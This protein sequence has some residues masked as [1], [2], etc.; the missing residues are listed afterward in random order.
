M[1]M[2]MLAILLGCQPSPLGP[3]GAAQAGGETVPVADTTWEGVLEVDFEGFE[4]TQQLRDD[5]SVF[6][7]ENLH[8][9]HVFL[10]RDVAFT[11][12]GLTR[13]M[14]FDWVDQGPNSVSVGRGIL[15]P[16]SV[17][18]IWTEVAVRFSANYT[19]CNPAKPPCAHKLLF[20]LVRPD[21][22]ERWDVNLGGAGEPGPDVHVTMSG[23]FGHLEARPDEDR[24]MWGVA[25]ARGWSL[26][27]YDL[28]PANRYFD[29]QWHVLRLHA[30]H[31]SGEWTFDARMRLWI[32]GELLYDSEQIRYEYG[33]GGF[34]TLDGARV[35]A[36]LLGRNKDK[37]LDKGTESVW[38]G[39]VRAWKEDP[40]W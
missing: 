15:L 39:R 26:I 9:D 5:R 25:R 16:H 8:S 30:K 24:A 32:D 18:E 6:A 4:T 33:A 10:D 34:S 31:S 19:P 12:A 14:R 21:G 20:L 35:S 13:S 27:K 28:A 2:L 3:A 1:Q 23:P 11:E 38:F 7:V 17:D 29:E 36:I 37:G 22:N 40:G